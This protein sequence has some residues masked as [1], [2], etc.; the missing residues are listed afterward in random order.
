MYPPCI[1]GLPTSVHPWPLLGE[2]SWDNQTFGL[3][4]A[5]PAGRVPGRTSP[6]LFRPTKIKLKDYG[7]I[8]TSSLYLLPLSA[9]FV[10][11]AV[12]SCWP[13]SGESAQKSLFNYGTFLQ[14]HRRHKLSLLPLGVSQFPSW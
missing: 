12:P 7:Y 5:A 2:D 6:L 11:S 14:T 1:Y 13:S 3:N 10:S 4:L 8:F 9:D